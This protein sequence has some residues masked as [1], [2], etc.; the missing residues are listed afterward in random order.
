[1]NYC[2]TKSI[3]DKDLLRE[4]DDFVTSSHSVTVFVTEYSIVKQ[5]IISECDEV[6]RFS[7]LSCPRA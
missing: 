7:A 1:M 6:T 4:C 5:Y 2:F 3:K